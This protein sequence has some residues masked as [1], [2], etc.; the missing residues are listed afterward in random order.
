MIA[1]ILLVYVVFEKM[2]PRAGQGDWMTT[3]VAQGLHKPCMTHRITLTAISKFPHK[4]SGAVQ[5]TLS[6]ILFVS[7]EQKSGNLLSMVL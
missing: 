1:F 6:A 5:V 3:F 2:K 7:Q 4:C